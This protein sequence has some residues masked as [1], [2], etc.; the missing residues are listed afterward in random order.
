MAYNF[1]AWAEKVEKE[2]V[3]GGGSPG[4]VCEA[5]RQELLGKAL[6]SAK[7][8]L[9]CYLKHDYCVE[10][11]YELLGEVYEALGEAQAA[12][13]TQVNA[14]AVVHRAMAGP[15]GAGTVKIVPFRALVCS[16]CRKD[17]PPSE[18]KRCGRCGKVRYCSKECQRAAWKGQKAECK[19]T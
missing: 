18:L 16:H 9:R 6:V 14:I 5:R 3:K 7:E 8:C 12:E 11:A 4:G 15:P 13:E 10:N 2:A 1:L 17:T 19:A